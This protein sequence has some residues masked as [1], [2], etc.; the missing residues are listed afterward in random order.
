MRT[1]L[2]EAVEGIVTQRIKAALQTS[3]GHRRS[4]QLSLLQALLLLALL[5]HNA[6]KH[7]LVTLRLISLA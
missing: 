7:T 5:K 4:Q 6:S 1:K 2:V 3:G